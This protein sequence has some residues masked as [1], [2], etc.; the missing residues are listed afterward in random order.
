MPNYPE[1]S[2]TI[3]N[4]PELSGCAV[5]AVIGHYYIL[6]A[7]VGETVIILDMSNPEDIKEVSRFATPG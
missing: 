7:T 5:P 3:P 6:P 1:L 2:R 4:Y